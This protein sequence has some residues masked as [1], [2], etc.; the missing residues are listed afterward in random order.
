M[1]GLKGE[2]R[3]YGL[4]SPLH[5]YLRDAGLSY[6]GSRI[7]RDS[8]QPWI[9]YEGE[10]GNPADLEALDKV[11]LK[12]GYE[13]HRDLDGETEVY[14]ANG[15]PGR[16]QRYTQYRYQ[17]AGKDGIVHEVLYVTTRFYDAGKGKKDYTSFDHIIY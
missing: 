3:A 12:Q 8:K 4:T 7:Q 9:M 2:R 1:K 14:P 15:V 10:R 5:I 16:G 11:L 13:H 6:K 17:K